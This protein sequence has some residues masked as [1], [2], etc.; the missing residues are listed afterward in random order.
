[1][2]EQFRQLSA[3][4]QVLAC[5]AGISNNI[6]TRNIAHQEIALY[7]KNFTA[8]GSRGPGSGILILGFPVEFLVAHNL[9]M[10]KPSPQ[11]QKNQDKD[12]HNQLSPYPEMIITSKHCRFL[13]FLYA[14][15]FY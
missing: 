4:V 3:L 7:I 8:F 12:R 1:M 13:G 10:V 9:H 14:K 15:A 11:S 6:V 5:Y 2:S